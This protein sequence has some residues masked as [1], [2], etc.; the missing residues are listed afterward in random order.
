MNGVEQHAELAYWRRSLWRGSRCEPV[1]LVPEPRELRAHDRA[2]NV[3]FQVDPREVVGRLTRFGTLRVRVGGRTYDLV[4]RPAQQSPAPS[5][6]Q[7]KLVGRR[8]SEAPRSAGTVDALL[9]GGAAARMGAWRQRLRSA[10][11]R[12][13]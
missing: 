7:E 11:A 9:N 4:G 1:V 5:A 6:G 10:G 12:L 3:V 8:R 13:D 2:L